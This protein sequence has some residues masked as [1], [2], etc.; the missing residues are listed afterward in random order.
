MP[1]AKP[2]VRPVWAQTAPVTEIVDP[3]DQFAAGG[4]PRSGVP[5]VRQFLNWVLN[6]CTNGIRYLCRRGICDFDPVETYGLH[7]IVR[8]DDNC[9]Y[10]SLTGPNIGN[11]PSKSTVHW[12]SL[13]FY[14]RTTAEI[15]AG[16]T[17]INFEFPELDVLRYGADN[18]GHTSCDKAISDALSVACPLVGSGGSARRV[19]FPAGQ[20]LVTTPIDLSN[21]RT[22]GT[23]AKDGLMIKGESVGGT[24]II[25]RTGAGRPVIE[26]TGSQWLSI[27]D[28]TIAVAPTGYSTV[29]IFQGLS[30]TLGE[31][32][33]Q[34]FSR[35]VISMS[36][37]P[38]ANGGAG[39]VGIWNFGAEENTYDTLWI[40]ANL[41]LMFTA[42]NPSPNTGFKTPISY[43]LLAETHSLGVCTFTGECFLVAINRRQ[44]SIVTEDTNSMK[45]VNTYLSTTG[46]GGTNQSAWK[47]HGSLTGVDFNGLI[48]EHARLLEIFG[49]VIGARMRVTFGGIENAATERIL[50]QRGG[51]GRLSNCDF[52]MTDSVSPARQLVSAIPMTP[53]ERI[54]CYIQNCTFK[55]SCDQ[56]FTTIQ[57]NVLWNPNTGNITIEAFRTAG[58]PYRYTIDSNRTQEVAI[59]QTTCL[60]RS[61]AYS[62]EVIEVELPTVSANGN[63]LSASIF[64]EGMA[65]LFGSNTGNISCKFIR[66][67]VSLAVNSVGAVT[68]ATDAVFAGTS[69]NTFGGENDLTSLSISAVAG[70]GGRR[71]RVVITP[72]RLHA[73][74]DKVG[75][76]GTARLYWNGNESRAPRLLSPN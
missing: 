57:E 10:R 17:P 28:L 45:F 65:Q 1:I 41:P 46:K 37:D 35:L 23:R 40:T 64:I 47:V 24:R 12:G 8:G 7:D 72:T 70:G 20:Y 59:P 2:Q 52:N 30:R 50:L 42:H 3:G 9:L 25:G 75:F 55:V 39:S 73:N 51:Q 13:G 19:H 44:P 26:T 69:A 21:S 18:T 27:E 66:A 31:T 43:Q 71:V 54:S 74:D 6:Y 62:A 14:C 53:N 32:Q 61:G 58:M 67:Q 76:L 34:R 29:G 48:E 60:S 22:N 15:A 16:V 33:N 5:P 49:T 38:T 68:V 63:A 4:F 56:Q 11:I 36:D